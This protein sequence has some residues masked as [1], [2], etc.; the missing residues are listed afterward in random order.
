MKTYKEVVDKNRLVI[1]YDDCESPREDTN[2]GYFLMKSS[3]YNSP[4][5]NEEL[6]DIMVETGE[7]ADD[8]EHH[9]ELMTKEINKET[10]EKVKAIYPISYYEHGNGYFSLGTSHG[11]DYSNNSFYIITAKTAKEFETETDD[12]LY[13]EKIIE[14][15]LE[16]YNKHFNGEVYRFTL[17]DEDGEA[18]DSCGG[19]YNVEDIMEYL[20]KEFKKEDLMEYFIYN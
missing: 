14:Q 6:H 12:K 1:E 20:P 10:D 15:E 5:T 3:K 17:Y 2:L 16:I 7:V 8:L 11:F 19:F 18:M 13:Y 9:I 4:D